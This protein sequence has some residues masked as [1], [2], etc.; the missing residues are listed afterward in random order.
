LR[1]QRALALRRKADG[2][3]VDA[4]KPHGFNRPW[5]PASGNDAADATTLPPPQAARGKD[6]ASENDLHPDD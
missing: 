2:F 3:D 6:A 5:A 1:R 4:V